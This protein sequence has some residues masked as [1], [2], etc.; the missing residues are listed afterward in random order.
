MYDAGGFNSRGF[1]INFM[2]LIVGDAFFPGPME[3][4]SHAALFKGGVTVDLGVLNSVLISAPEKSHLLERQITLQNALR[5][6]QRGE[7]CAWRDQQLDCFASTE[8]SE[9]PR[10]N[11]GSGR[12]IARANPKAI[13]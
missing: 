13:S 2:N 9:I 10:T 3:P 11:R 8:H 4:R 12:L 7:S 6:E 5:P 1:G